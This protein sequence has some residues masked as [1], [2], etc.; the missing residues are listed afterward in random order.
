MRF[1][2]R[3]LHADFSVARPP[4]LETE[5]APDNGILNMPEP[6]KNHK[7]LVVDDDLLSQKMLTT[8]L[9]KMGY[10]SDLA[11]NGLEALQLLS[12][13][14]YDLILMDI[15]MPVMDG[16]TAARHICTD[17]SGY[18]I[19]NRKMP[20]IALTSDDTWHAKSACREVGM[21]DF[22]TKPVRMKH[23]EEIIKSWLM[24]GT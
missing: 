6:K 2:S 22:L 12:E 21:S 7:I 1:I 18:P 10:R 11:G 8:M 9:S 17:N 15:Q 14:H 4:L 20:I 16:Y 3:Q 19:L 13:R 5:R 24:T 23:L